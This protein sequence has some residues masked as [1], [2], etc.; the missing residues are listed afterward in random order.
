M[1][2]H[3]SS[4]SIR[5]SGRSRAGKVSGVFGRSS[6]AWFHMVCFGSHWDF[7]SLNTF[8][9]RRYSSNILF[10]SCDQSCLGWIVTLPMKYFVSSLA[11]GT[12][13]V[14][15]TNIAFCVFKAHRMIGSWVWSIHPLFQSMLGCTATNQGYPRMTLC[16][17]SLDKKNH[18]LVVVFPVLVS[19]ST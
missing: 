19:R 7:S 1:N 12:F 14:C 16:S 3:I 6:I 8:S 2:F 15:G 4:C 13:F 5:F 11:Q 18:S 9:C 17:P 10:F